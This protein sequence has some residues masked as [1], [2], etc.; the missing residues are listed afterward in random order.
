MKTTESA[1]RPELVFWLDAPPRS[2]AG[3][4][5]YV[6][7]NWGNTVY[8]V[9]VR[10]LSEDRKRMG[11]EECEH[12]SAHMTILSDLADPDL[13]V[14]EFISQHRDAIH[15]C[16]GFRSL[17]APYVTRW[18]FPLVGLKIAAWSE[19]PGVYENRRSQLIKW[20][21]IAAVNR[22]YALRY[23]KNIQ[24]YLAIGTL[25][26]DA[27][28]RYGWS[29]SK[30]FPFMYDS[31]IPARTEMGKSGQVGKPLRFLYV[32]QFNWRKGVDLLIRSFDDSLYGDWHLSLVGR[33]GEYEQ[34]IVSWA[35]KNPRISYLG[36]WSSSEVVNNISDF[37]VC[38]VPSRFDGWGLFTNEAIHA[39]VG[40]IVS[41]ATASFD[42]VEASGAGKVV[43][44]GET[45]SFRKAV[46]EVI[47]NPALAQSWKEKAGKYAH[48]ITSESV[49]SY[50]IDIL[51]FTFTK[52]ER[53]RPQCPWL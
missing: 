14:K 40:V 44:S 53:Q 31:N 43:P 27:F 23:G 52:P 32:G 21:G 17:V 37:D 10:P 15:V 3:T 5:R 47:D 11:W 48:K 7:Q 2:L 4:L 34:Q 19:R 33:N 29:R 46:Q 49:G 12:G 36:V 18:L 35:D 25:S 9:C 51:E 16:N 24:A 22:F 50:L 41:D 8:Y 39:G 38:L 1:L 20:L 13:F 26:V 42:L 6:S 28:E 45:S 30:L